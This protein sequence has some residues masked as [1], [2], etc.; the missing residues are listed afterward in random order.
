MK[1]LIASLAS[2]TSADGLFKIILQYFV[3]RWRRWQKAD[4]FYD[5]LKVA[6]E[7]WMMTTYCKHEYGE[8][9]DQ[10]VIMPT[11]IAPNCL[12]GC[13]EGEMTK[14]SVYIWQG[15]RDIRAFKDHDHDRFFCGLNGWF[16]GGLQQRGECSWFL[17][18]HGT[19]EPSWLLVLNTYSATKLVAAFNYM[20][21]I[22]KPT[23]F[24]VG[25]HYHP[26][27]S[28]PL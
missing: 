28:S 5:K 4:T 6:G 20:V 12:L 3:N 17:L 14:A 22:S 18:L 19:Y 13:R 27:L 1:Y 23:T 7:C 8:G 15:H 10:V 24:H 2:N 25:W 11:L 21:I 16:F 26:W 9:E